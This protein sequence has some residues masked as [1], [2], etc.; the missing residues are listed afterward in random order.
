MTEFSLSRLLGMWFGL[1]AADDFLK[2]QVDF[3]WQVPGCSQ[4]YDHFSWQTLH[5]S[6]NRK[7]GNARKIIIQL[8]FA[9]FQPYD[10][11]LF[12]FFQPK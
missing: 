5:E 1:P 7:V 8:F 11:H 4:P 2:L 6:T 12:L 10:L 3:S 9:R